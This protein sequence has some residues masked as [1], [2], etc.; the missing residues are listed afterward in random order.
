MIWILLQSESV[1]MAPLRFYLSLYKEFFSEIP[2][3]SLYLPY[4]I[5]S[6]MAKSE[7]ILWERFRNI[8]KQS[9]KHHK[10]S[11]IASYPHN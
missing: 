3:G 2:Q 7:Q 5:A 6:M 1:A 8:L 4:I 11:E 9:F 10:N